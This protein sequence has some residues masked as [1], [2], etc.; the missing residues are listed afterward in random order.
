MHVGI[1]GDFACPT[2]LAQVNHQLAAQ[3]AARGDTVAVL[4]VNYHGDPHP[5]PHR[6]YPAGAG[7]GSPVGYQRLAEFVRA[8]RPDVLLI[9]FDPW[10]V[11]TFLEY[12]ARDLP[13]SE[14]P[15]VVAYAPV[16]GEGLHPRDGMAL[17][18]CAHVISYTAFGVRELRAAGYE[19]PASVVGLGVDLDVW[20]PMDRRA[21]RQALGMPE[22]G[23]VVLVADRNQGRKRIDL[24]LHAFA[25]ALGDDPTARLI[26][27]GAPEE[28]IGYPIKAIARRLGIARQVGLTM[29]DA[30]DPAPGLPDEVRRLWTCAADIRLSSAM[31]EGWGLPTAEAMACGV[32]CIA[33]AWG[34]IPEWAG[35]AVRLVPPSS[36]HTYLPSGHRGGAADPEDLAAALWDLAAHPQARARLGAAGRAHVEQAR[37]RWDVIGAQVAAVLGEVA[38]AVP[39]S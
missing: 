12:L 1:V 19:G 18:A 27:H 6:L 2:G 36:Y 31:G 26:Y 7:G 32:P 4:A 17:N 38:N 29:P 22:D 14:R 13:P 3:L 23:I 24:A 34:G 33:V 15:P 35:P 21:A 10:I 39:L 5:H 11:R 16:D 37:F 9:H 30:A 25:I 28:P 8:E 20:A